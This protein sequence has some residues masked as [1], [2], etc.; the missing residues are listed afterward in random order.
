[1]VPQEVYLNAPIVLTACEVRLPPSGLPVLDEHIT[2]LRER[3]D[4]VLPVFRTLSNQQVSVGF[5]PAGPEPPSVT[6]QRVLQ[7][8]DRAQ[9]LVVQVAPDS[10]VIKTAAYKGW[11][12]FRPVIGQVLRAARDVLGPDGYLRVGL[13]YIDEIR[14]SAGGGNVEDWAGYLNPILL[15]PDGLRVAAEGLASGGWHVV[16]RFTAND[17]HDLVLRYGP[18]EGHAINP[19]EPPLPPRIAS[20]G[21]FFLFDID[22]FWETDTEIPEF[23]PDGISSLCDR[24]HQPIRA[25]FDYAVTDRLRDEVLRREP[26]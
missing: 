4:D 22:S 1:V 23:D 9:S 15:A 17:Q 13:R 21:P 8:T 26:T 19:K 7:L 5:G 16:T 6:Q 14:L 3:L 10:L 18:G 24:L 20:P 25:L 2:G 12:A 11:E